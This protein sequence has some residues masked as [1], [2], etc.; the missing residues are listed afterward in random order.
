MK[1]ENVRPSS[2][3]APPVLTLQSTE[4]PCPAGDRPAGRLHRRPL[5]GQIPGFVGRFFSD[6]IPRSPL[7]DLK[8]SFS[9][10]LPGDAVHGDGPGEADED[11]QAV[12]GQDS[13]FGVSDAQR[14][15]GGGSALLFPRPDS[16]RRLNLCLFIA[17]YPLCW[18]HSQSEFY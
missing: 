9:P 15:E 1:H 14:L 13:V 7:I 10:K 2:R 11:A 18:H 4:C 8:K 16:F 3:P 5:P 17:V 12:G 6:L